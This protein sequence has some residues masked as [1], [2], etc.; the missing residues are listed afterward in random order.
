LRVKSAPTDRLRAELRSTVIPNL[1]R[2]P[3]IGRRYLDQ[4]PQSTEALAQLAALP[5]GAADAL[6][7]YLHGD[8]LILCTLDATGMVVSCCPCGTTASSPS[9]S[10]GSGLATRVRASVD[11]RPGLRRAR[12]AHRSRRAL[13]VHR[14]AALAD[15]RERVHLYKW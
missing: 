7:E 10:P 12:R 6:R 13:T 14:P 9:S 11:V 5:H 2:F 4:P 8:C 3:R 1:R 15:D